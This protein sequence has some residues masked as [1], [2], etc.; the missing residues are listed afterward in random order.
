MR[1][2]SQGF[3]FFFLRGGGG[4]GGCRDP[5]QAVW[6][7]RGSRA[8]SVGW[9]P[10][11]PWQLMHLSVGLSTGGLDSM[12]EIS[13]SFSIY[14]SPLVLCIS[15]SFRV[16]HLALSSCL[17]IF[18]S[19]Y[20]STFSF[21]PYSKHSLQSSKAPSLRLRGTV[22]LRR[23]RPARTEISYRACVGFEPEPEP[24]PQLL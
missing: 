24:K 23:Q 9:V 2:G 10:K 4:G 22:Q 16:F 18:L 7:S 19:I 21:E 12:F 15:P 3:G 17:S 20:L 5:L 1:V 11:D 8:R 14:R 13:P 6:S